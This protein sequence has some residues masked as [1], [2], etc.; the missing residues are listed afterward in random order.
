[1]ELKTIAWIENDFTEKFGVPRQ[2]GLTEMTSKIVFAPEYRVPEAIRGLEGFTHIWLLWQFSEAVREKWSPTVRPP[3]L[4]GNTRMGVFATRSPFR[5][6]SIGLSSVRLQRIE[7][8]SPEGPVLYVSGADLMNKTPIIDI[9]PYLA[10]TDS[11]PEAS[12]GFALTERE[13]RLRV[14]I[15]PG[16]AER[17]PE[18]KLPSLIEILS[19]DPRPQYQSDPERIYTMSFGGFEISF[20]VSENDLTVTDIRKS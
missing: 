19:Q 20:T 9:K 10:Y 11:H 17:L 4:G 5:P 16:L 3:R 7:P 2:S 12:G 8:D 1:M 6:N 14:D 15:A 18:E 13:G